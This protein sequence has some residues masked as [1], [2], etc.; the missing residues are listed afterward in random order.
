MALNLR[1]KVIMLAIV[2]SLLLA[3]VISAMTFVVL[4]KLATEEVEQTRTLLTEER[5]MSLKHYQEI[6]EASI[7]SI[8]D[9]SAPGDMAARDKAVQVL[10]QLNYDKAS[11]FYGY[12]SA[13]VR[14]FWSDKDLDIGKNFSEAKDAN[15]VLVI[16]GL[17]QAGK[18]GKHFFRYDWPTPGSDKPQPKLGYTTYLEKWDLV[19]GT[20]VNLDDI[21]NQV[22]IIA[23]DRHGRIGTYTAYIMG[24]AAVLVALV[25]AFGVWLSNSIV[26]PILAI[27]ACSGQ[28][29][30]D[31]SIGDRQAACRSY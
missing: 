12:N 1:S 31:T 5:R 13:N 16:V 7:K 19:F 30:P 20:Q 22:Q 27:K 4:E 21:E 6:G 28:L 11:Y 8:Y 3:A 25:A 9:A 14:V 10:R 17:V 2:P 26:R 29:F 24:I 23:A 18:S 15:G